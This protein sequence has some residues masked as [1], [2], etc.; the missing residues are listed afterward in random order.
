MERHSSFAGWAASGIQ[1][2]ALYMGWNGELCVEEGDRREGVEV[3]FF[4]SE[5]WSGS[6]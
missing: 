6:R 2:P 4:D 5:V 3:F 1:L